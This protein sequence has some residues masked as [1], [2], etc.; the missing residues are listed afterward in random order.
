MPSRANLTHAA[1]TILIKCLDLAPESELAIVADETTRALAELFVETAIQLEYQPYILYFP[2]VLQR[3]QNQRDLPETIR[4]ALNEASATIL[5]VHGSAECLAFREKVRQ[6]AIA[7]GRKEAHMPGSNWRTLLA[8]DADYERLTQQCGH[9]AL[10]LAKGHKIEI[11][12]FDHQ[13]GVHVLTAELGGWE[14][15][16]VISDGIIHE[17][18]WGNVP[19]GETFI[20]PLENTAEG[21]IVI[22]GSLPGMVLAHEQELVLE[23]RAGR[24]VRFG[25]PDS[26]AARHLQTTFLDSAQQRHDPNWSNLA[27]IGLGVNPQIRRLTGIPLLDEKKY[28]TVHVALG[29]STDMGGAVA[30][31]I[32]CD[33][34]SLKPRVS[35]DGKPILEQGKIVFRAADWLED[36]RKGQIRDMPEH[37]CVVATTVQARVDKY[38]VLRREWHTATGRLDSVPV[39]SEAST[40]KAARVWH[41]LRDNGWMLDLDTLTERLN[42][43]EGNRMTHLEVW[44]LVQLL[45]Q[46]GLVQPKAMDCDPEI[47]S[48]R[49][50]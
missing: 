30:S 4:G 38:G 21:E 15:L 3:R 43:S 14:R 7:R 37:V 19:S 26:A 24:L 47:L 12:S 34:V 13:Q 18:A 32:H 16:P 33:M 8:A 11:Q 10:A 41:L 25:P 23:F 45:E 46:Y 36:H 5:C 6:A 28:G 44:R 42:H 35:I 40:Q 1:Q 9:L 17:G 48:G 20:A 27:E 49:R 22:D 50:I 39:G 2:T 29:D 31:L